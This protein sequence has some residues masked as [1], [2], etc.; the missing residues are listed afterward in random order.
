MGFDELVPMQFGRLKSRLP[1]SM[2]P[3]AKVAHEDSLA[4]LDGHT[5]TVRM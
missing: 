1:P 3:V 2:A 5:P 4:A